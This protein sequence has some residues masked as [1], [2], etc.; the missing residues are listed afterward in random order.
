MLKSFWLFASLLAFKGLC[1]RALALACGS[2][3]GALYST[4]SFCLFLP[5]WERG[6]QALAMRGVQSVLVLDNDE[7]VDEINSITPQLCTAIGKLIWPVRFFCFCSWCA[8]FEQGLASC[9][10]FP[11]NERSLETRGHCGGD[12]HSPPPAVCI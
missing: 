1:T 5:C 4:V 8:D 11:R 10:W 7:A 9:S 12:A 3:C 2:V 6:A